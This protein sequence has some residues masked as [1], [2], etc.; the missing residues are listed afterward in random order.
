MAAQAHQVLFGAFGGAV[1]GGTVGYFIGA[2]A[3]PRL[4]YDDF[5]FEDEGELVVK[6]IVN[7]PLE[8]AIP[9]KSIEWLKHHEEVEEI[10]EEEGYSGDSELPEPIVENIFEKYSNKEP[11]EEEMPDQPSLL[12][13]NAEPVEPV[14]KV[15]NNVEVTEEE[16][17]AELSPPDVVPGDIS[18]VSHTDFGANAEGYGKRTLFYYEEDGVLTNEDNST[19]KDIEV[20]IGDEALINFGSYSRDPDV[21]YIKND[22]T[23]ELF[24]VIHIYG[25]YNTAWA[26]EEDDISSRKGFDDEDDTEEPV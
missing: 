17:V 9:P 25:A 21:V 16:V 7:I 23:G 6:E 8:E 26:D 3:A 1:V 19:I 18:I 10:I 24:E 22:R 14:A 4:F 2:W 5:E 15:D 11:K 13:P 20:L 12:F